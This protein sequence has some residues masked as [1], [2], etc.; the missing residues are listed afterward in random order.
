MT[1]IS[2]Y[3]LEGL[4][5]YLVLLARCI[6]LQLDLEWVHIAIPAGSNCKMRRSIANKDRNASSAI[7]PFWTCMSTVTLAFIGV[8]H[9]IQHSRLSGIPGLCL[10]GR[11]SQSLRLAGRNCSQLE[12]DGRLT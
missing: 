3:L 1:C 8:Y 6:C 9:Q 7:L 4:F 5:Y 12:P 10:Q 11:T 2:I